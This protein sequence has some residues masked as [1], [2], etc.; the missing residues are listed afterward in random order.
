MLNSRWRIVAQEFKKGTNKRTKSLKERSKRS[1]VGIHF[2]TFVLN[3]WECIYFLG[4]SHGLFDLFSCLGLFCQL[5]VRVVTI[6][7]KS[8]V[9]FDSTW[10]HLTSF[11]PRRTFCSPS[12]ELVMHPSSSYNTFPHFKK[13]SMASLIHF[14]ILFEI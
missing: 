12:R 3:L 9:L 14:E 1:C 10:K 4:N 11:I 8:F 5:K 2:P 6:C 13:T 7:D